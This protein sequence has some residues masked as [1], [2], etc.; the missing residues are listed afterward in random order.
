[1]KATKMIA[2]DS[3][4]LSDNVRTEGCK[5]IP[6]MVESIRRNG[7]KDNHPLVLSA[8]LDGRNLVLCGNRRT[9][10]LQWLV[11][12]DPQAY[13][14]A[15]PNGKL[16]CRVYHN[17]TEEEEVLLRIDHSTDEDRV[18]LDE[19]SLYLAVQQLVKVGF[20]T[21]EGIAEKLGMFTKKGKANRSWVQP[22]VNLARLP[23]F[24]AVELEKRNTDPKSTTVR[25]ADVPGLY[26]AH[27]EEFADFPEGDGPKFT[28]LWDAIVNPAPKEETGTKEKPLSVADAKKRALSTSSSTLRNALLCV[29]GQGTSDFVALDAKMVKAET[30]AHILD[31]IF[32]YL[33]EEKYQQLVADAAEHVAMSKEESTVEKVDVVA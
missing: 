32:A 4:Y 15:L 10:A 33:G 3:L 12:N 27:T 16:P 30:A 7:F 28:T 26:K 13:D 23:S 25:W 6:E 21:Q 19:W 9:E 22:R 1:M 11:E 5:R 14:K 20:D 2:F 24:V 18:S 17:L 29:T 8:K 31:D